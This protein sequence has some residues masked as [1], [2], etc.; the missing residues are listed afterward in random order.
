MEED[1]IMLKTSIIEYLEPI[2]NGVAVLVSI[3]M[4]DFSFQGM[5]WIHP[6]GHYFLECEPDFLKLWGE[7]ETLNLPFYV[8]LCK[9][10]ESILPDKNDI[11]KEI[12]G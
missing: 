9:D 12:L 7:T 11:F 1:E 5:Y 8:D 3:T 6:E 10:I 2:N 4:Y